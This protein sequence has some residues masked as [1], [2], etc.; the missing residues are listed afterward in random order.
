MDFA[1]MSTVAKV[2]ARAPPKEVHVGRSSQGPLLMAPKKSPRGPR[3]V[4]FFELSK[5]ANIGYTKQSVIP[6]VLHGLDG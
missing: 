3:E 5:I 6:R 2:F 4:H 1:I